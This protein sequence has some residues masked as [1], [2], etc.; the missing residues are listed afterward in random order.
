[1]LHHHAAY[2]VP[3][4]YGVTNESARYSRAHANV[5]RSDYMQPETRN[6]SPDEITDMA[7]VCF[8]MLETKVQSIDLTLSEMRAEAGGFLLP[9]DASRVRD[10][11]NTLLSVGSGR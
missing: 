1:M 11:A 8:A 10:E 5:G 9:E 7:G 2:S 4:K 3:R 6:F